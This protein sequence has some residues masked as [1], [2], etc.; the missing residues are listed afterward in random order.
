[1]TLV[2]DAVRA[3]IAVAHTGQDMA[4]ETDRVSDRTAHVVPVPGGEPSE[5]FVARPSRTTAACPASSQSDGEPDL[6]D[7]PSHPRRPSSRRPRPSI[8]PRSFRTHRPNALAKTRRRAAPIARS[9]PA[10]SDEP[11]RTPIIRSGT[12]P[13][14]RDD[15]SAVIRVVTKCGSPPGLRAVRTRRQPLR[16]PVH[17]PARPGASRSPSLA[18]PAG[19]SAR[20]QGGT[21]V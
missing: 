13:D 8:P 17:P 1:M 5:P 2:E 20:R 16:E 6:S 15:D 10:P 21:A 19:P 7:D 4:S 11:D 14:R 9:R 12:V 18:R 3:G